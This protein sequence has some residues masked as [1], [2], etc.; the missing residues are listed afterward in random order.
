[1]H[2]LRKIDEAVAEHVMGWERDRDGDWL[3]PHDEDT[4]EFVGK[5]VPFYSS[6]IERAWEVVENLKDPEKGFRL[7]FCDDDVWE[8]SFGDDPEEPGFGYAHGVTAPLAISLAALKAK[9]ITP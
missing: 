9:G 4:L 3:R 8:A 6:E 2:D 7:A 1:M 5:S